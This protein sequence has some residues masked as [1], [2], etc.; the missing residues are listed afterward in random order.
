MEIDTELAASIFAST[1][2]RLLQHREGIIVD[3]KDHVFMVW[4]DG[5]MIHIDDDPD[6]SAYPNIENGQMMWLHDDEES[7][8][9]ARQ[10]D[11]E[12]YNGD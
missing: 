8:S 5:D 7:A 3:V 2:H 9:A 11:E 12:A 1:A 10:A 6:L 4:K